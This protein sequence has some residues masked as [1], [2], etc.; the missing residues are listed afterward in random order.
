MKPTYRPSKLR[1]A[2]KFGFRARNATH[3]GRKVLAARRAK[4]RHRLAA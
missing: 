4:G 1:R 2:R 3:S